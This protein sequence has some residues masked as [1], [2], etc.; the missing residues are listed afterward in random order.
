MAKQKVNLEGREIYVDFDYEGKNYEE[1]PSEC[2][3]YEVQGD[4]FEYIGTYNE[5]TKIFTPE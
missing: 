2:P 3:A 5:V 1:N 4:D